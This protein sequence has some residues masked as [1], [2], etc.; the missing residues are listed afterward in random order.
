MKAGDWRDVAASDLATRHAPTLGLSGPVL[1]M[2]DPLPTLAR[3]LEEDGLDVRRYWRRA[4][5]GR[6]ASAW[7]SGGAYGTVALRLP[8]AKEELRMLTHAAAGLM[9]PGGRFLLYGAKDEGAGSAGAS[10]EEVFREVRTEATGGRCRLWSAESPRETTVGSTLDDWRVEFDPGREELGT[11]WVSFPGVFAHG[12][13]DGGTSLLLDV[14]PADGDGG[15]VLDFG[16]GHGVLGAVV[17][18]RTPGARV[19]FLDVDAVALEAVRRNVPSARTLL[20][21][22]WNGVPEGAWNAVVSNPPWHAGKP[23]TL[24]VVEDLVMGAS[25]KLVPGGWLALVTQRRLPVGPLL[26]DHFAEVKAMGDEGAWRV[27]QAVRR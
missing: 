10:I 20:G 23:E 17:A 1:V 5:S 26:A 21:D 2:E 19:S 13:L 12:R 3:T 11:S 18:V 8:R 25:R 27:W 24:R 9:G 15:R 14:M 6:H 22:G 4:V 16:C 7:P